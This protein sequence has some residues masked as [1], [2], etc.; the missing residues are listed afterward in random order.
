MTDMLDTI[1]AISTPYGRGGIAVIR[2]SGDEAFDVASSM[3][4]PASGKELTDILPRTAV[5][6][7]IIADGQ[8]IDDGIATL[9]CAPASYTGEDTVEISCHGGILLAEK[10]LAAAITSGARAA[11]AGEF[12]RR[13]F[14][15]GKLTL[16]EAEAVID[17]IDAK[18]DDQISLARSQVSGRLSARLSDIY[19][20]LRDLVSAAYVYADYPDEDLS[21]VTPEQMRDVLVGIKENLNRLSGG[22]ENARLVREGISAVLVGRPNT[23]KSSVLN[24][25][26]GTDRA[27]VSSVAG[28]TRDTIE[29]SITL[30]RL[31]VRLT[32]TA[33][34]RESEDEIERIGVRR[35]LEALSSADLVLAVFDGSS[36]LKCD[37]I[38]LVSVL[39]DKKCPKIALVN[40]SD[41]G[42]AVCIDEISKFDFDKVVTVSALSGE[43]FDDLSSAVTELFAAGLVDYN[44]EAVIANARQYASITLAISSVDDA[45][46]ALDNR[47]TPD[48]A[49]LD[50]E[51]AMEAVGQT[52]GRAVSADI[53]DAI[54]HRF[55]VGK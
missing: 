11:G 17:L 31:L 53:V 47:F 34:V 9:F 26:L 48:V 45:I 16:T 10:V 40:K 6:G 36:E 30:G 33:G 46:S 20:T 14:L 5:Y 37:D 29:E 22:Y 25:L 54:F 51:K 23:G 38:E 41:L 39:K 12:T 2:I 27:I 7:Q 3:F 1:A 28:T 50:I 42:E 18:T 35:S 24:R 32:D 52:D 49:G 4:F 55:C 15:S 19:E 43:G 21:D 13:A 44:N 8:V